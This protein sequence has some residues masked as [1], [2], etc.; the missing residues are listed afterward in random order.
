MSER[1][2][3]WFSTSP[4]AGD[5]TCLCSWCEQPIT[6]AQAPAIRLFD[7]DTNRE[8]RFHRGC[9]GAAMGMASGQQDDEDWEY[10]DDLDEDDHPEI[11]CVDCGAPGLDC[12]QCCGGYLCGR[13][14]ETGCGFCS[15]CPTQECIDEWSEL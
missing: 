5:P 9:Y 3:T 4:D 12:C 14:S 2:I 8:A 11:A 13:H 6:E 1:T 10:C 15:K 7:S